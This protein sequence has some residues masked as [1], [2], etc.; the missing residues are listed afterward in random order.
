MSVEFPYK[1]NFLS[2]LRVL[3]NYSEHTQIAYIND[4]EQF[5]SFLS[6]PNSTDFI[7]SLSS[8]VVRRWVRELAE[9]NIGAKSIH[10]KV[11]SLKTYSS[12]L[13]KEQHINHPVSIEVQLPKAKKAIPTYVK[14]N[15]LNNLLD[16]LEADATTYDDYLNFMI[17][18]MFYHTGIRR[19][20]LINLKN[21]DLNIAQQQLKVIGKGNKERRIP[22]TEELVRQMD[23]FS[24]IKSEEGV[25]SN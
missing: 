22:I 9:N 18:S 8:R 17:L 16:Q 19:S 24:R 12:F 11:S 6:Q 5:F 4:V 15:E 21:S 14:E 3:K 7:S 13:F 20:E 23:V 1:N 2:Y 25:V 10:R